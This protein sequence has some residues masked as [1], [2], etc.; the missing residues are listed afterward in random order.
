[1]DEVAA[2]T[3]NIVAPQPPADAAAVPV[4]ERRFRGLEW[5]LLFVGEALFF[6][7]FPAAWSRVIAGT[8]AIFFGI[9]SS[10]EPVGRFFDVRHWS[11]MGYIL[12][13]VVLLILLLA[14]KVW[15]DRAEFKADVQR[16]SSNRRRR[17]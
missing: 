13:L 11:V 16:W 3:A 8:K 7:L 4:R 2:T 17:P 12:A 10:L 9:G 5:L 6:Q 14:F 15:K 1:M